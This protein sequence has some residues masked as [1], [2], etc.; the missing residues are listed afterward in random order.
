MH[1]IH[2]SVIIPIKNEEENIQKLLQ[3]L[4]PVMEKL[5]KTWEAICIDDGSTDKSLLILQALCREKSYLRVLTFT[6]NFGQSAAFA[7][8]FAAAKGEIVVTLDGDGQNDPRDIPKLT[9]A[10]ADCDLVVGWRKQRKDPWQKKIISWVSNW[11]R[12]HLCQDEMHDTGCSLKAYRKSAL[13]KIKMYNGMHR[14]LPAL[15]K[16]EGLTVKEIP[17]SHR[18]RIK[19]KTKYHFFNRSIWPFIDMLIVCWMRKRHLHPRI[20]EEISQKRLIQ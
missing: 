2:F 4:E 19:G 10:L 5:G 6:R 12:R 18:Q 7:A 16:I 13:S 9:A 17:V 8:G 20:R 14:F 1:K 3:E 15:F 11:V